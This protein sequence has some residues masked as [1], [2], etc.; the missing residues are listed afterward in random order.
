M[1][2]A[3]RHRISIHEAGHACACVVYAVPIISVTIAE[4]PHLQRGP[5][6]WPLRG[7]LPSGQALEIIGVI[8]FSGPSAEE[9]F[10]GPPPPGD[11]GGE[12]RDYE[13]A[14]EHLQQQVG[15]LRLGLEFSRLRDSARALV[16]TPWAQRSILALAAALLHAGTLDADAVHA[17]L[18]YQGTD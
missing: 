11:D 6:R 15:P 2:D 10:C 16:R 17:V 13:M 8:C 5:L 1:H 9:L 18:L 7:P 3:L 4:P 14:Y 12:R